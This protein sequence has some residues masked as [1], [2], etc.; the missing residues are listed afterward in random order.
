MA[1]L[2]RDSEVE[3]SVRTYLLDRE[4]QGGGGG[5]ER[6]IA[7][8]VVEA[9]L[10]PHTR[11]IGTMSVRLTDVQ[12]TVEGIAVT[13]RAFREE[14]AELRADRGLELRRRRRRRE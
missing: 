8:E 13:P 7:T 6:E 10:E 14:V 5:L 3:R 2:L 12:N 1:V 4:E 9:R 11:I